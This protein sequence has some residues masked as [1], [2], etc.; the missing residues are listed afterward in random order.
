MF[1]KK[2]FSPLCLVFSIF[3]LLYII[4]K[5]QFYWQGSKNDYYQAYYIVSIL[6]IIC[7]IISFYFNSKIKEYLTISLLSIFFSLYCFDFYLIFKEQI[8][9]D[10]KYK[11]LTG[12]KFDKRN[13]LE[14]YED[15]KKIN[16]KI[17]LTVP[18]EYYL[19]KEK[20]IYPLSGI[21]NS[22]TIYCNENGYHSI[23]KSDRYGFNNPDKEWDNEIINYL[24]V[25]D[26]FLHGACVNRP[27]DISSVLRKLSN[28]SVLNLGYGGN[29]PLTE[30]A[31]LREY[32]TPNVKNVLWIYYEGNDLINLNIELSNKILKNYIANKNFSQNLKE[33]QSEIDELANKVL[34][35]EKKKE[36]VKLKKK[37][38][39]TII[40][41]IKLFHLRYSFK[42]KKIQYNQPKPQPEFK[43][44]LSLAKELA[45]KNNS[46]FFFIYLPEHTHINP[47]Y[48]DKNYHLV[49]GIVNDL[50]I[51]F[52]D[53]YDQV[54]KKEI[55]PYK[56]F[57][58]GLN[59][60]Y[61]VYGYKKTAEIIYNLINK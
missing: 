6:L 33:K 35:T 12:K 2:I 17:T 58:F 49:K 48:D 52:I 15:L 7:S 61:N 1:T 22:E 23:Y 28:K 36:K 47:K 43:K 29:G 26:S 41:F 37:R 19:K 20:G 45:S 60:H 34:E 24:I 39:T 9:K 57:S 56:V 3:F 38:N 46:K 30:Y 50:S 18:P 4:Y 54:F 10:Y 14:I 11:K 44:I 8:I 27:N 53:I 40:K 55:D 5:S 32:F 25:G 59:G 42:T 31:T 51:P 16:S 13:T 21:S